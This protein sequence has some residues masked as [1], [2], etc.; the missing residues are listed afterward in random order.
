MDNRYQQAIDQS[1][2]A[3]LVVDVNATIVGGNQRLLSMLNLNGTRLVNISLYDLINPSLNNSHA[4]FSQ[5]IRRCILHYEIQKIRCQLNKGRITQDP[6]S[7]RESKK[8]LLELQLCQLTPTVQYEGSILCELRFSQYTCHTNE[9]DLALIEKNWQIQQIIDAVPH[10]IY[11]KDDQ[12]CFVLANK[13]TAANYGKEPEDIIGMRQS[14]LHESQSRRESQSIEL[15]DKEVLEKQ[16]Q[17]HIQT[18]H[19]TN[20]KGDFILLETHRMPFRLGSKNGLLGV[21]IDITTHQVAKQ[22]LESANQRLEAVTST[23]PDLCFV[24]D[25]DGYYLSIYGAPKSL[26]IKR[27][28]QLYGKKICDVLPKILSNKIMST[29]NKTIKTGNSQQ[30]EYKMKVA[31]GTRWFEGRTA[32]LPQQPGERPTV[33]WIARDISER[34]LA[35]TQAHYL[36]YHDSLTGLPNRSLLIDRMEQALSRTQREKNMGAVLFIDLDHFKHIN[37]SLGH[38]VGDQLLEQVALRIRTNIRNVDTVGRLGGD[39]FVVILSDVGDNLDTAETNTQ[40]LATK[41]RNALIQPFHNSNHELLIA[42]SIGVVI[43]PGKYQNAEEILS[44]ADTA[45][46]DAKSNGR[47]NLVFFKPEMAHAVKRRLELENDLRKAL[48]LNQFSLNYQPKVCLHTGEVTGAEALL[49]WHHP[50][51]GEMSP[52]EFIP[53]LEATGLILPI[54]EW[55]LEQSSKQLQQWLQLGLWNN[56]QKLSVNISPR[57]FLQPDFVSILTRLIK[58]SK[59]PIRCID[60]EVTEGMVIQNLDDTIEKMRK[61]RSHGFSF[62]ID[63]FG[64]GYSSLTYLKRLPLDTLKIDRTFIR[65][66]TTD[67]E[68][69]AIVETILNIAK[70]FRLDVVA[71]GVETNAQLQHLRD[72]DCDQCQG[73]LL[74][75][76]LAADRF[77]ALLEDVSKQCYQ[78][79]SQ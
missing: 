11:V 64:T 59:A 56:H 27:E 41:L 7:T 21:A 22:Q 35:E 58:K 4:Q 75:R 42:A 43:F 17:H 61:I 14:D 73:F 30:L 67:Q 57:Q 45:M 55:V 24:T 25:E 39:E 51:R 47:D 5:T 28:E 44:H 33:F 63:D 68:D 53:I 1:R 65:D 32:L 13:S 20:S 23:M 71:E 37:D 74:S 76:P 15:Y 38:A 79:H 46:Y 10:P 78:F 77:E 19:F 29:I 26:L 8:L 2:D 62:S 12:G 66:I 52:I 18:K 70:R 49:R 72:I 48:K 34:K 40:L 31:S 50:E 3:I 36:A 54:G 9:D 6:T 60:L 16:I 69:A